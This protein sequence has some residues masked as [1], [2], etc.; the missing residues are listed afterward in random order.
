MPSSTIAPVFY[1]RNVPGAKRPTVDS[2]K[3]PMSLATRMFRETMPMRSI[4]QRIA[5]LLVV[6]LSLCANG[7][8]SAA[9]P[10]RPII[11]VHGNGDTAGLWIA[12]I[13]RFESNGY[14]R[15]LLH[16]LDLRYPSAR[17]MD[18]TS[19]PGRSSAAEVMKQLA[20]VVAQVRQ[21]TGAD[22]V[23]LVGQSRGGNTVRNYLKNGD[24]AGHVE[25]AVLCGAVNHGVIV[26][27][28]H[29]AGSEFNGASSFM[30]DLNSTA[31]EVLPGVRFMTIRSDSNDKYAQ[32]D[33]RFIG[34]PKVATGLGYDAPEL[35]GATNVVLPAVD[36]RET[37]YAPAA[38][39]TM[40]RYITGEK[41]K[42]TDIARETDV[43]L[44]GKVSVF[45]GGAPTNIGI[46][47]AAVSIFRVSP[48]T[49]ERLGAAE[50]QKTT[51]VDGLWG[52]FHAD[53][54]A[55]YEFVLE[56]PGYPATHIY[57]SPFPRSSAIVHIRPQLFGKDDD[58]AGAVVYMSRP[59]GYFGVGR[60]AM[61]LDGSALPGI[62]PGVPS[63]SSARAAF[64][65][66]PQRGVVGSFN[67]EQIAA[68][69]WPRQDNQVSVIELTY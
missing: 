64:P 19:Q 60:D 48:Q 29:L 56:A 39:A 6:V 69:T 67:G 42:T 53:P 3:L 62:A 4:C 1:G 65:A 54:G 21:R 55:Y 14:P 58:A 16:A 52:P 11:F 24:G 38:F 12:T 59:R 46:A 40:Y 44:N 36:H 5:C 47:G 41:P 15:D 23:V 35:K 61:L 31:G 50:H 18:E 68:R 37:G 8:V 34:L 57:R 33:G 9:E 2:E 13:W 22:K 7:P 49:G 32:A 43:I 45:E 30:K 10:A 27:G 17:S 28:E 66:E 25:A 51:G 26:S 20:E 63:V